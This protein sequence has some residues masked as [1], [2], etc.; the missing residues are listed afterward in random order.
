MAAAFEEFNLAWLEEPLRADRPWSEWQQ[1]AGRIE[2]MDFGAQSLA[3]RA[4]DAT[5]TFSFD[6]KTV[7]TYGD[8]TVS[9][10]EMKIGDQ[11][12]VSGKNGKASAINGTELIEGIVEEIDSKGKKL[13]VKIG[14][15]IKEIPFQFFW[16]ATP[17]GKSSPVENMKA[18]DKVLL[19]VNLA[20][21]GKETSTKPEP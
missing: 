18:G 7:F 21:S 16:V 15:R 6:N 4:G 9:A 3:I 5:T 14:D 10:R 8:R 17:D 13:T 1:L 19:N 11:V 12:V 2:T 20:L